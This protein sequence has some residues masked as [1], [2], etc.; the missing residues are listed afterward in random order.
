MAVFMIE[1]TF[2]DEQLTKLGVSTTEIDGMTETMLYDGD[3]V[4][5]HVYHAGGL[6]ALWNLDAETLHIYD[7]QAKLLFAGGAKS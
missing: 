2:L 7:R 5:A 1:R 3:L 4:V 6:V